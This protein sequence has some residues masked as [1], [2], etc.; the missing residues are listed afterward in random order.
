MLYAQA[1][2]S[3]HQTF[4]FR[5][6]NYTLISYA[7]KSGFAPGRSTYHAISVAINTIAKA[8]VEN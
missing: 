7:L 5:S 1:F 6:S 8:E 2:V 4:T 3:I